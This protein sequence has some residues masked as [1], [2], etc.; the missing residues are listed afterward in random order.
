[1]NARNGEWLD[2]NAFPLRDFAIASN[3]QDALALTLEMCG[4]ATCVEAR[5]VA[6]SGEPL[7]FDPVPLPADTQSAPLLASNGKDYLAIWA[8]H[9]CIQTT[10]GCLVSHS[11]IVAMRLGADGSHLDPAP[12]ALTDFSGFPVPTSVAWNGSAY[13]VTWAAFGVT[14]G[15][16]I[17]PDGSVQLLGTLGDDEPAPAAASNGGYTM[18]A[19]ARIDDA[20]GHIS[21]VFLS[22]RAAVS[23]RRAVR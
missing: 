9:Q 5:H 14:S 12:I 10:H 21:R 1:M 6:M 7:L 13:R 15:A 17:S 18:L 20:A 19:Y 4:T 3:G 22:P 8:D 11:R 16:L 23:R 2:S